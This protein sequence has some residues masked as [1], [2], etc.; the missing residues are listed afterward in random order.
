M[1]YILQGEEV[2]MWTQIEKCCSQEGVCWHLG[3]HTVR[4]KNIS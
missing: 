3:G 4:I 1:K 2:Q